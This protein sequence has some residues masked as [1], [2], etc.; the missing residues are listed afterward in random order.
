VVGSDHAESLPRDPYDQCRDRKTDER[1]G[2]LDDHIGRDRKELSAMSRRARCS[3]CSSTPR[4]CHRV[5]LAANTSTS[6]SSPKP[7]SA[8]EPAAIPAPA[9]MTASMLREV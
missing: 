5:M 1:V 3:R 8:I 6:E 4:K 2:D 7:T 9:A